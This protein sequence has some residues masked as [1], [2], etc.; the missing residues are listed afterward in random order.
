MPSFETQNYI[1]ETSVHSALLSK[2]RTNDI[3]IDTLFSVL[4]LSLFSGITAYISKY[5]HNFYSRFTKFFKYLFNRY[6]YSI[7]LEG[8]ISKGK[9]GSTK[10]DF[11][12]KFRSVLFY[13]EQ[14]LNNT[15]IKR[16]LEITTKEDISFNKD[17]EANY[18]NESNYILDQEELIRITD[19]IY[20][21]IEIHDENDSDGKNAKLEKVKYIYVELF[22]N[23]SICHIDNFLNNAK[24]K[25]LDMIDD[26]IL[27]KQFLFSMNNYDDEL[28]CITYSQY[29][30]ETSTNFNNIFFE[31][32]KEFLNNLDFFLNNK[33]FYKERGIPYRLGILLH[34]Y[35]GCGKT[36][37]IKCIANYTNR[38][39]VNINFKTIKSKKTLE[40]IFYS[41][42]INN[43]K[44]NNNNKIY[45]IE[46]FDVN[47]LEILKDRKI[48]YNNNSCN[49]NS[50]D[51]E[52]Y[53]EIDSD[54]E[55]NK[56]NNNNNNKDENIVES[57]DIEESDIEDNNDSKNDSI[58]KG[59]SLLIK[60]LQTGLST[61]KCDNKNENITLGNLLEVLD[62]I[63]ETTGRIIIFTTN[64][65]SKM[66]KALLRPGRVDFTI[67]FK[68]CSH[69]IMIEIFEN[70]FKNEIKNN[71]TDFKDYIKKLSLT[72]E[73]MYSPAEFVN[74][75]YRH[76]Y[77]INELFNILNNT[78]E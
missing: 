41:D 2:F 35:P 31:G 10:Y 7:K 38:H 1:M 73:Y 14:N 53:S 63:I 15:D 4:L 64:N 29:M 25:Y 21:K 49:N 19:N 68:K 75:C 55:S 8:K 34:G 6:K 62:G 32:K 70:F 33:D 36:S 22:S 43:Y 9:Y 65:I 27:N 71:N 46:E 3:L 56:N 66:D 60:T 72:K 57:S 18:K 52:S 51:N 12:D 58:T 77:N 54:G 26:I 30:F 61:S 50:N 11:S 76:K 40:D 39:I 48:K 78:V 47:G 23:I 13:I 44:L 37:L 24:K 69:K 42:Y 45:L 16:I 17:D 59:E 67:E 28:N 20:C 5:W 74:L